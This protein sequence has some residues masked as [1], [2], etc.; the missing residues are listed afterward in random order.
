ME[1]IIFTPL[2]RKGAALYIFLIISLGFSGYAIVRI[3]N[4]SFNT[5]DRWCFSIALCS[6]FWVISYIL[7]VLVIFKSIYLFSTAY[8]IALILFH[9][10][11]IYQCMIGYVRV[12]FLWN[13]RALIPWLESAGWHV[14]LA[15]SAFGIGFS[16]SVMTGKR[17]PKYCDA[18]KVLR[19]KKNAHWSAIGLV[20]AS[21]IFFLFALKSYGN[22]LDYAR[23]EIFA[24]RAD[25]RGFGAFM[26]IFPGSVLV[27]FFSATTG[28]QK[29]IGIFL[30]AFAFLVFMAAGYRS[31]ALFPLL[32]GSVLWVKSGRRLPIWVL[33]GGVAVV[34]TVIATSGY[35]RTMGKYSELGLDDVSRAFNESRMESSISEMGAS[36]NVL[37]S[38]LQLVP[39]VDPYRYG[40][41]YVHSVIDAIPNITPNINTEKSREFFEEKSI[42]DPRS[43]QKMRPADWIT[44]RIA[45]WHFKKGYGVGFSAIAEAYLNFSTVGVLIIFMFIGYVLG[46]LDTIPLFQN[47]YIFMFSTAML[48]P[49]VRT[50]R[51]DSSNF[52]KPMIFTLCILMIWWGASRVFLGK[53]VV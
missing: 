9:L 1:E 10:G 19:T 38:V 51:N 15:L 36:I 8:L 21:I 13:N 20:V 24:S 53:K 30:A 43:I 22:L 50:V 11:L 34:L 18:Q 44:Y 48:W 47:S 3:L 37:A 16:V 12:Q 46:R 49:L 31:A 29:R 2:Y 39:S 41:S 28:G 32:I 35:L 52:F 33:A 6:I 4:D 25:S 5:T 26:M 27:Y 40:S 14:I 45:P 23:H 42:L 17:Y 7:A